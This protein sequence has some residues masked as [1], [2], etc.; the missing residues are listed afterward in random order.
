MASENYARY[1]IDKSEI[2]KPD[3]ISGKWLRFLTP[4]LASKACAQNG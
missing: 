1:D 2:W 3:A 4:R